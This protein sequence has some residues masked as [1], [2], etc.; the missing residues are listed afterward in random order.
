MVELIMKSRN[1]DTIREQRLAMLSKGVP[2]M[3]SSFVGDVGMGPKI[4]SVGVSYLG[5]REDLKNGTVELRGSDN[6]KRIGSQTMRGDVNIYKMMSGFDVK[7][8]RIDSTV[9][10][11]VLDG[12]YK[13][14]GNSLNGDW[15][16]LVDAKRIDLTIRKALNAPV[17]GFFYDEQD[18]PDADATMKVTEFFPDAIVFE[19]NNGLGQPVEMGEAMGGQTDTMD[20]VIYAAGFTYDLQKEL[21][22]RSLD[23]GKVNN[24]VAIGET[25]KKDD[26]ALKPI[27]NYSYSAA[28]KTA[29]NVTGATRE[30]NLYLTLEDAIDEIGLRR[31]PV[32]QDRLNASNITILAGPTDARRIS[33]VVGGFTNVDQNVKKRPALSEV[34]RIVGYEGAR[35]RGRSKDTNYTDVPEGIA[36]MMIPNRYMLLAAKRR[37]QM[38]IDMNPNV[39]RLAR[40]QLAWWY[41]EAQYNYGIGYFIQEITL[42][43]W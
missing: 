43:D 24:A 33:R 12:K 28:A 10:Q 26:V 31:D 2:L 15:E 39:L 35:I 19:E 29:A 13:M 1:E 3:S 9:R 18:T 36:Y 25:G 40:Q 32:T 4:E 17:R 38:D 6:I 21:F 23:F 11:A 14:D 16:S 37:L 41:A 20:Q 22:D 34:T 30:E 42:S 27:F 7:M 8:E 5:I